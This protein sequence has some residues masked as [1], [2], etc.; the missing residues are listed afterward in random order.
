[1]LPPL[2]FRTEWQV[3]EAR[4][5]AV[6]RGP[7]LTE[8]VLQSGRQRA[9]ASAGW[10]ERR[11]PPSKNINTDKYNTVNITQAKNLDEGSF[12][13]LLNCNP[14]VTAES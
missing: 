13:G 6:R 5:A 12:Q 2:P 8:Q 1:M 11:G 7:Q 3:L 10:R 14:D 9:P 4:E